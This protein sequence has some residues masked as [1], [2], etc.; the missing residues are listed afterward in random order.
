MRILPAFL[1]FLLLSSLAYG[2]P[3][4]ISF[5]AQQ[6]VT[7]LMDEATKKSDLPAVVA[8]AINNKNQQA[9]YSH[10]KA[11][12]TRPEKVT[13]HHI[14]RIFSMTKLV[15][16][17]AAMQLVEKGLVG[18]DDDLSSLLPEMAKIP[19][20][21]KGQLVNP[22]NPI[23][24]RHLLTHTSGFGYGGTDQALAA[25][26]QSKWE[27]KDL[28]RRFE[29]G[30]QFLYGSSTK[31]VG[32]LVEKLSGM[33][34]ENY[35]RQNITGPL[36]M[37]RTWFN[38]P[39]SLKKYIV[40]NG[41]RGPDG[42]QTLKELPGRKPTNVVTE[43]RGD[44]GLFSTPADFTILL[45]CLLNDG[46]LNK[47]TLLKKQTILEM[48]ANQIGDIS[49]SRE[50]AYFDPGFCCNFSGLILPNSKWGLA[51]LIDTEDKPYGPK[52]GTVSWGGALNTF[53]YIDFKS[54]VAASIFT[55]HVPFNHPQTTT[56]FKRF[57]EILY[58]GR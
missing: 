37:N 43:F 39:D 56:L 23:T 11:V 49:I 7:A 4:N 35:F 57:S 30:T 21:S 28:P 48:I 46:S 32:K 41:T 26:D 34:L 14:F 24:L 25:F 58:S 1:C 18:L 55:Q 29:S 8:M 42:K 19:I 22:K 27:F 31:W 13:P 51:W 15:T 16:S 45:K 54:G 38:V 9:T 20:L 33:N 2:Q 36:G 6:R 10:G 17:I 12:W 47:T 44:G 53:F 3:G 40:S 50:G 52:A 5:P